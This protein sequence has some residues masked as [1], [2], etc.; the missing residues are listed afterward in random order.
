MLH[1]QERANADKSMIGKF[2]TVDDQFESISNEVMSA[3]SGMSANRVIA[4]VSPGRFSYSR[5]KEN[6]VSAR[7]INPDH[8]YYQTFQYETS[9]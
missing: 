8:N 3:R 9:R 7:T 4:A 1:H 5:L 2:N 6:S